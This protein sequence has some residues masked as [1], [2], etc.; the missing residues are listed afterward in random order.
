[1]GSTYEGPFNFDCNTL[2]FNQIRFREK[3]SAEILHFS[4]KIHTV[5]TMILIPNK[6]TSGPFHKLILGLRLDRASN[7][8]RAF[9]R[10][11]VDVHI[12][13]AILSFL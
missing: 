11:G 8:H 2:Q 9:W 12:K 6:R 13:F 1:M 10:V 4:E 7:T 3:A 5:F